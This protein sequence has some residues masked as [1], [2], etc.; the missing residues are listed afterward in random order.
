MKN[1]HCILTDLELSL[2]GIS[3]LGAQSLAAVIGTSTRSGEY[4][5]LVRIRMNSNEIGDGG[6]W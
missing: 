5:S 6:A 3:V 1:S 2:N 4:D